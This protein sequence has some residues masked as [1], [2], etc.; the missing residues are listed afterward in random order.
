M[1]RPSPGAGGA[2]SRGPVPQKHRCLL[3]QQSTSGQL[4]SEVILNILLKLLPGILEWERSQTTTEKSHAGTDVV[5][6]WENAD[7]VV[8]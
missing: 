1:A 6:L 4:P 3:T 5:L 7:K 8:C 2:T